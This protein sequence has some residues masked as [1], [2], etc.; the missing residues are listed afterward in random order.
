MQGNTGPDTIAN[1]CPGIIWA[2][3]IYCNFIATYLA[4]RPFV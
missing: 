1:E 2:S 4:K 3:K